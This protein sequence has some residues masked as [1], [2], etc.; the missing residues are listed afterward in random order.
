MPRP[1]VG[2]TV[3]YQRTGQTLCALV[4]RVEQKKIPLRTDAPK[5]VLD[6]WLSDENNYDVWLAVYVHTS[7]IGDIQFSP[8]PI[9]YSA[10]PAD[11]AWS[12]PPR[13]A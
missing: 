11:K 8:H 5:E 9:P 6:A 7:T 3:H 13:T 1:T 4:T 12:W 2:R 10:E